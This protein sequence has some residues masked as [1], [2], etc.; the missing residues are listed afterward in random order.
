MRVLK[1]IEEWKAMLTPL[2][3]KVLREKG[4]EPPHTGRYTTHTATGT[5]TCA[6]CSTPLFP[7]TAKFPTSCGWPAFDRPVG[8]EAVEEREDLTHG[9]V[10]TEVVCANCGGHLGHVFDDGPTETGTRYCI[11]S[12]SLNFE[13]SVKQEPSL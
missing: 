2:Q 4:T 8:E 1:T 3:F 10:R 7:S 13:P 5:Y 6:G 11:N 9:M 12:V